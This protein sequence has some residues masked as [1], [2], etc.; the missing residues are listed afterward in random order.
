M[1]QDATPLLAAFFCNRHDLFWQAVKPH[2][3]RF[4]PSHPI[5]PPRQTGTRG[6][7]TSGASTPR[8]VA[9]EL[10]EI[11]SARAT[12]AES[13]R[14]I[15][16]ALSHLQSHLQTLLPSD[17]SAM[18]APMPETG[19][20]EG[21]G[22]RGGGGGT[23]PAGGGGTVP[24]AVLASM[25]KAD[26]TARSNGPLSTPT[27]AADRKEPSLQNANPDHALLQSLEARETSVLARERALALREAALAQL[28]QQSPSPT[29][30]AESKEA[31]APPKSARR[32]TPKRDTSSWEAEWDLEDETER[33]A[34]KLTKQF[35]EQL[36]TE[37]LTEQ[38]TGQLTEEL[39]KQAVEVAG[40]TKEA[41]ATA[42]KDAPAT[43]PKDA[44]AKAQRRQRRQSRR[45]IRWHRS[46]GLAR[47]DSTRRG[48]SPKSYSMQPSSRQRR[49]PAALA[50][51][52]RRR[53]KAQPRESLRRSQI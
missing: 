30:A 5:F 35:T 39:W 22:S 29:V 15:I 24:A 53:R 50:A 10:A 3:H 21:V 48:G 47:G 1:R 46:W 28:D 17:G 8:K 9:A 44:P 2:T 16:E 36:V 37:K 25:Q 12:L 23:V 20:G 41:P 51:R 34:E 42:P 52:A 19:Q 27:T 14:L 49:R 38:L 11:N 13:E 32:K 45:R 18:A 43:A 40:S 33:L 7:R 31:L 26:A 6:S 4:H